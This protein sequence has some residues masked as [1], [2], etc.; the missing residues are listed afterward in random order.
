MNPK[1]LIHYTSAL[2][3]KTSLFDCGYSHTLLA[4]CAIFILTDGTHFRCLKHRYITPDKNEFIPNR[5]LTAYIMC[6]ESEFS[7]QDL[8]DALIYETTS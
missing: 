4:N 2:S 6:H 3:L 7:K 8:I 1:I 5:L